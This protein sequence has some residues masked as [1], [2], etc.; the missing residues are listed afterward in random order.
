MSDFRA[1]RC[2]CCKPSP[3]YKIKDET[4]DLESELKSHLEAEEKACIKLKVATNKLKE[5]KGLF[6]FSN[7]QSPTDLS[8]MVDA[9]I[10]CLDELAE[11]RVK[12]VGALPIKSNPHPNGAVQARAV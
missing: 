12:A 10:R 1:C 7:S 11:E 5:F 9:Y 4:A 2:C 6:N 8:Y 3:L